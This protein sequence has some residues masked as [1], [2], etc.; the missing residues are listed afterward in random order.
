MYFEMT[1]FGL[2]VLKL[3]IH[4]DTIIVVSGVTLLRLVWS[5]G[6]MAS[7]IFISL[8]LGLDNQYSMSL[9]H[10]DFLFLIM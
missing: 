4:V 8:V 10:L 9:K 2:Q 6:T 1:L 3:S 5:Q 7:L